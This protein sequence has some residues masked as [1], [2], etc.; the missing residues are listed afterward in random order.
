MLDVLLNVFF[1]LQIIG[2]GRHVTDAR[3]VMAGALNEPVARAPGL[4][5]PCHALA[6]WLGGVYGHRSRRP[7]CHAVFGG[8]CAL[9]P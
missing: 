1:F 8:P 2:Q 6:A 9:S 7:Q 4:L 5:P 3:F